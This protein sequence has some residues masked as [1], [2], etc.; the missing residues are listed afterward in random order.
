MPG[1][2]KQL[3]LL[4]MGESIGGEDED[5]QLKNL[6]P[7]YLEF[8]RQ[9]RTLLDFNYELKVP[10]KLIPKRIP[11]GVVLVDSYYELRKARV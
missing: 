4:A 5:E 6:K 10:G 11:G 2:C 9:P 8:I 7:E 3:F 1:T